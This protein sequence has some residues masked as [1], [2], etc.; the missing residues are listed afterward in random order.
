MK[1]YNIKLTE[2]ETQY[3]IELLSDEVVDPN[4]RL[5]GWEHELQSLLELFNNLKVK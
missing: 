4:Q 2:A 5:S 3:I 1:K